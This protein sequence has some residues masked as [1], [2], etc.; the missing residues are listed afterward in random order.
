MESLPSAEVDFLRSPLSDDG[1]H[2][3]AASEAAP[4]T[5]TSAATAPKYSQGLFEVKDVREENGGSGGG[6]TMKETISNGYSPPF[7]KPPTT[8]SVYQFE[9]MM[10]VAQISQ[11]HD[12]GNC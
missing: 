1:C 5:A 12:V 3:K 2:K 4:Q 11:G 9:Y 8:R 10:H 7:K 6:A